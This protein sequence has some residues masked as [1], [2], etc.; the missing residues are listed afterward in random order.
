MVC[1]PLYILEEELV[2]K[3]GKTDREVHLR[4]QENY[5]FPFAD[6][7]EAHSYSVDS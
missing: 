1:R 3:C 5:G 2:N 7:R 4:P 6:F